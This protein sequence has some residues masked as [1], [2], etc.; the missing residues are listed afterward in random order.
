M[1]RRLL[2]PLLMLVLL[3]GMWASRSYLSELA[4]IY[5]LQRFGMEDVAIEIDDM[6]LHQSNIATL[7]FTTNTQ[8]GQLRI[9]ARETRLTYTPGLLS[10]K[11]IDTLTVN[12]VI[13]AYETLAHDRSSKAAIDQKLEP[14][15]LI[16]ALRHALHG[17]I[18]FNTITI[19]N[20]I[21]EGDSFGA[22]NHKKLQLNS[23]NNNGIID[24]RLLLQQ[25]HPNHAERVHRSVAAQVSDNRLAISLG[26]PDIN[27]PAAAMLDLAIDNTNIDGNYRIDFEQLANWLKPF[28][29]TSTMAAVDE[30]SGSL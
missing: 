7:S 22:L 10:S 20:I 14:V 8:N 9:N 28:I 13:V 6:G 25:P 12:T 24:T 21:A 1:S 23:I 15:K 16:A 3:L 5:T 18:T 29:D 30:V 26:Y 11:Q 17:Y 19:E 4:L 27:Q 2:F